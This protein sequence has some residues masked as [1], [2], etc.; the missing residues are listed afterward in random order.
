MSEPESRRQVVV[1]Q[2]RALLK[3]I[4]ENDED[5]VE[6]AV[7]ALSQS[8]RIFAPLVFILGAFVML[9]QGLRTLFSNWRLL[10]IQIPPA[11][12]IWIAFLDLKLHVFKGKEF[13]ILSGWHVIVSVLAV[14][15][16]TG[17]CFYLNAVFAF[18]IS[19]PGKPQIRPAFALARRHLGIVLGVGCVVGVALGFSAIV[20]PRWGHLWFAVSMGL[21]VGVMMMTYVTVPA[22]I[23][24]VKPPGTV[25]EKMGAA[26]LG[27]TMSAI[28]CAP[29]YIIGRIGILLLGSKS[30]FPLAV[31]LLVVGFALLSGATGAVKA[32]KMSA[33]LAAGQV[34]APASEGA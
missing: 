28:V 5:A 19:Q 15:A 21:V 1:R 7:V 10:L 2:A 3:A 14:T 8:K 17:A 24:G 16:V 29:A 20:V 27:G 25:V 23:I 34:P 4:N 33:K 22:R 12:W 30:L 31:A 9:F 32:I 26:A 13:H 18:A 6:R 11:M